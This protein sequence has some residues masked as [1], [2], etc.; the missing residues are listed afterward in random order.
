VEK[1]SFIGAFFVDNLLTLLLRWKNI[2][3][4]Y[5]DIFITINFKEGVDMS[6]VPKEL[7]IGVD[8]GGGTIRGAL[9]NP[10]TWEMIP[11]SMVKFPT[12]PEKGIAA[13]TEKICVLM[14]ALEEKA[15]GT[16]IK[17]AGLD[18]PGSPDSITGRIN[19]NCANI[20]GADGY[21]FVEHLSP[22]FDFL[23]F[24]W[25]DSGS[26][27][28]GEF[29][30]GAGVGY[31]NLVGLAMGSGIGGGIIVN[32]EPIRGLNQAAGEFGH[33]IVDSSDL[34]PKCSRGDQGCFESLAGTEAIKRQWRNYQNVFDQHPKDITQTPFT[35]QYLPENNIPIVKDIFKWAE[36]E[37]KYPP[38][39]RSKSV[40]YCTVDDISMYAS[41]A[42][43]NIVTA[44]APE[45]V[46]FSG[47]VCSEEFF[48]DL[49]REKT[50]LLLPDFQKNVK[51]VKAAYPNESAMR[52]AAALAY[53]RAWD[54]R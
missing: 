12:E 8:V 6:A 43:Y 29:K 39:E 13:V 45:I 22:F 21:S 1:W 17:C 41:R 51:I 28:F 10:D 53:D 20:P 32:G 49:I 11:E 30:F 7:V 24:A 19:G 47:Q 3:K 54:L 37:S 15:E 52:G 40:C 38:Y 25:N 18:M 48:V 42:V 50:R 9:F 14:L 4:A 16:R 5:L 27:L 23:I 2:D 46:I 33:M 35:T 36:I 44:L 31:L 26:H 34:A